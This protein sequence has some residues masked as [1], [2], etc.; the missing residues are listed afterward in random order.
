MSV[1][2]QYA[3]ISSKACVHA[4]NVNVWG[5]R[6]EGE[7]EEEEEKEGDVLFYKA[8][9]YFRERRKIFFVYFILVLLSSSSGYA[10]K[11]RGQGCHVP[12]PYGPVLGSFFLF[13]KIT[14]HNLGFI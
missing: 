13:F 10:P 8:S 9:L 4:G 3:T 12:P 6:G 7:E 2:V 14:V 5:W 1:S 11:P